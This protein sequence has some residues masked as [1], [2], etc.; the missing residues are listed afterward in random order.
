[1]QVLAELPACPF[2]SCLSTTPT[3]YTAAFE[4]NLKCVDSFFF[5]LLLCLYVCTSFD[6]L[7]FA[8]AAWYVSFLPVNQ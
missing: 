4:P 1:M 8:A 7:S 2:L 6:D 3:R 5:L